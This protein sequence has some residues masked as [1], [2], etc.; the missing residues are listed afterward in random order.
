MCLRPQIPSVQFLLKAQGMSYTAQDAIQLIRLLNNK[1]KLVIGPDNEPDFNCK[2]TVMKIIDSYKY[3]TVC[4][5]N[6]RYSVPDTLVGEFVMLKAYTDKIYIYHNKEIVAEG[7]PQEITEI[8][9]S[10][11][12]KFLKKVLK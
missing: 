2:D 5:E 1:V 9:N 4:F 8:K 7:T 10:Y 6:N 12:G 3:S 11:T